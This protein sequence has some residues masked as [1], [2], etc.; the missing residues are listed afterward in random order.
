MVCVVIL[1]STDVQSVKTTVTGE[2]T[3]DIQCWFVH[4]SDARGC[5]VVLISEY[6]DEVMIIERMD[7]IISASVS[8]NLT[9]PVSCYSRVLAFDVEHNNTLSNLSIEEKLQPKLSLNTK[10]CSGNYLIM[11]I[12][13]I[14]GISFNYSCRFKLSSP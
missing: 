2:Y 10:L 5:K 9:Y 6:K 7:N 12:N 11:F 14:K 4:G 3:I 8:L 1:D 13:I